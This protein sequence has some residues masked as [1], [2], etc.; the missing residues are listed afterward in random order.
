MT[1]FDHI[2]I[3]S[4][5][6][7]DC[8]SDWCWDTGENGFSDFD[9][10]LVVRGKG[11]I[12]V[13]DKM[14]EV[15]E[16]ACLILF[17]HIHYVGTHDPAHPLMTLNVHFS[18]LEPDQSDFCRANPSLFYRHVSDPVYLQNV[19]RRV[20]RLYN[21]DLKSVSERVFYAA[22]AELFTQRP[23]EQT[24]ELGADKANLLQKICD[25]INAAQ[26]SCPTLAD[27][28]AEYGYSA[29]Y[30]GRIF[31]KGIGISF[32]E[33]TANARVNRAKVLLA[34]S[35]L[36]LEAIAEN[37]GYYDVCYFSRQFR[38]IT[39][40]SPGRFRSVSLAKIR[41]DQHAAQP[42]L[43]APQPSSSSRK[44]FTDT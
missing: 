31:S 36:S 10:W 15:S 44:P 4:C 17:P 26:K 32:S 13:A 41:R 8:S 19:L 1:F 6:I 16:G 11:Q 5:G 18:I 28:A 42:T 20:I 37:L 25:R 3:N 33:Y 39:G 27:F 14:V 34:S 29:D 24:T 2:E 35:D 40:T 43:H 30:L 7:S 38:R 21:A 22:L 12:A 23:P 9:L